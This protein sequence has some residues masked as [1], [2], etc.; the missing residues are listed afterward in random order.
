MPTDVEP[1]DPPIV[2]DAESPVVA[3]HAGGPVG[4]HSL[5]VERWMPMVGKP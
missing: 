5:E 3:V 4:S 1:H 2:L